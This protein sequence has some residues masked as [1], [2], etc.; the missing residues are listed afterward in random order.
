ME[1]R[2]ELLFHKNQSQEC[3]MYDNLFRG[4]DFDLTSSI[5]ATKGKVAT[6]L[7]TE[8]NNNRNFA[9]LYLFLSN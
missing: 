6:K 4:P 5:R 8:S 1:I 2:N 3:E 9:K 7:A